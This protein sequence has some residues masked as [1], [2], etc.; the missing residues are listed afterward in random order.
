M[1]KQT[2]KHNNKIRGIMGDR[3]RGRGLH[4]RVQSISQPQKN[5]S[6]ISNVVRRLSIGSNIYIH[7]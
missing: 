3:G 6:T 4:S 5:S 1:K 7:I 2:N